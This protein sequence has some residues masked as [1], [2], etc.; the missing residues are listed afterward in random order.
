M[1]V[2]QAMEAV[3]SEAGTPSKEV[4]ITASGLLS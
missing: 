4:Q 1:E 3:G 2:A